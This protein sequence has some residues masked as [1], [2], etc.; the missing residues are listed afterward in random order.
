[1]GR[2]TITGFCAFLSDS[3]ISWKSKKQHTISRSSAEAKYRALTA[4]VSEILG[5]NSFF[6]TLGYLPTL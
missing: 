1:M 2:H 6:M 4:A 5:S 3:L